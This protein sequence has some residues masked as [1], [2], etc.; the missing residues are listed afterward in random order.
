M[1][2]FNPA[3][4]EDFPEATTL[5][6]TDKVIFF[7]EKEGELVPYMTEI[8]SFSEF[9]VRSGELEDVSELLNTVERQ[10]KELEK[11]LKLN[12]MTPE[13]VAAEYA[14]NT[15]ISN[16]IKLFENTK[17]FNSKLSSKATNDYVESQ[18]ENVLRSIQ[19]V[20]RIFGS[21]NSG[22]E[23]DTLGHGDKSTVGYKLVLG[24]YG[25]AISSD[26]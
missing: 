13:E 25:K 8:S 7:T 2:E 11:N 4:I 22:H 20:K 18:A 15:E 17:D 24:A 21:T 12:Y 6:S 16:V 23:A 9:I 26:E 19:G 5:L 14:T 1:T 3:L 10:Y